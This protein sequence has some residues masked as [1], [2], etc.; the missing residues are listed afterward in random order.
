MRS[1]SERNTPRSADTRSKASKDQR[2]STRRPHCS[3]LFA[4]HRVWTDCNQEGDPLIAVLE[5]VG[6]GLNT[7]FTD[8]Q[9]PPSSSRGSDAPATAIIVPSR[10][11]PG[12]LDRLCWA[13]TAWRLGR[14]LS[15]AK[16]SGS[17]H[18]RLPP[19]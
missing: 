8:V 15:M 5:G 12:S 9:I 17:S 3:G 16:G 6:S 4:L 10:C 11:L 18:T 19:R 1:Q 13:L 2:I 14:L 7:T